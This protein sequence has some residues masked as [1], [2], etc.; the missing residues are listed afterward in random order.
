MDRIESNPNTKN[1]KIKSNT[2]YNIQHNHD[3]TAVVSPTPYRIRYCQY[4]FF[5]FLLCLLPL[6]LIHPD[7][8]TQSIQPMGKVIQ[9]QKAETME[10]VKL[11]WDWQFT[12]VTSTLPPSS[13]NHFAIDS[14][15][16]LAEVLL[17]PPLHT[18]D[19]FKN[20]IHAAVNSKPPVWK[21]CIN[22]GIN[23]SG[24]Y[25]IQMP[26]RGTLFP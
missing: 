20:S 7:E 11:S 21:E 18:I 19:F 24:E 5:R 25:Q 9:K 14:P 15:S 13:S 3:G 6:S 16:I 1:K 26:I 4:L 22:N 12:C 8:L 17:Q 10:Q 23:E 2:N